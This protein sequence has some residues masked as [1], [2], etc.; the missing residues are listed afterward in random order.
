MSSTAI[1]P[2]APL[3][4]I[5]RNSPIWVLSAVRQLH[6]PV[7]MIGR[8][9]NVERSLDSLMEIRSAVLAVLVQHTTVLMLKLLIV[10]VTLCVW[11]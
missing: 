5:L 7:C 3:E 1:P 4:N 9:S 11:S 10:P 2:R 8:P 6:S